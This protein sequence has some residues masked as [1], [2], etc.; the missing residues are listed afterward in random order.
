MYLKTQRA[1]YILEHPSEEY[2]ALFA[3]LRACHRLAHLVLSSVLKK[4][5]QSYETFFNELSPPFHEWQFKTAEAVDHLSLVIPT[6]FEEREQQHFS[7]SPLIHQIMT[8][9]KTDADLPLDIAEDR[10]PAL[11]T[12]QV[13]RAVLC[14]LPERRVVNLDA[15]GDDLNLVKCE[16]FEDQL[17]ESSPSIIRFLD[18]LGTELYASAKLDGTIYRRGEIVSVQ[19]NDDAVSEGF[20]SNTYAQMV[21]FCQI[22]YFYHERDKSKMLHCIWLEHSSNTLLQETAHSQELVFLPSCSDIPVSS[23][24]RRC[25]VTRLDSDET[26]PRDSGDLN[27][28]SYFHRF[29]F[30]PEHSSYLAPPSAVD[31]EEILKINPRSPCVNCVRSEDESS[32]RV[33]KPLG[34]SIDEG[35]VYFDVPYHLG[36]F[37]Y[38]R[39][40]ATPE[41][42]KSSAR[43]LQIGQILDILEPTNPNEQSVRCKIRYYQRYERPESLGGLFNDERRLFRTRYTNYVSEKD[44]DGVCFVQV[45]DVTDSV[46]I[47][48]WITVGGGPD[49]FY[50][51][52]WETAEH[53]IEPMLNEHLDDLKESICD[54]CLSHHK[55]SMEGFHLRHSQLASLDLFAG[56]GGLSAGMEQSGFFETRWAV[57][58]APAAAQTFAANHPNALVVLDDL[59][60]VLQAL[61]DKEE[62][63]TCRPLQRPDG[64]FIPAE[65]LPRRG[66]V[67][68]IIMGPPCQPFSGAN[69]RKARIP[70]DP[71]ALLIY[72]GLGF[73]EILRPIYV[74]IENVPRLLQHKIGDV[75]SATL[76]LTLRALTG[77]GY[78]VAFKVLQAGEFGCAQDRERLIIIAVRLDHKMVSFPT[79]THAC[80]N[81]AQ[82][83]KLPTGAQIRPP[84]RS[85]GEVER[86]VC[87]VHPAVKV[88]DVIGDLPK[89]DWISPSAK[90]K[91]IERRMQKG[92][93]QFRVVNGPVGF[94]DRVPFDLLPQTRVQQM[95]RSSDNTVE[96]HVTEY[97]KSQTVQI[98]CA[99]PLKPWANHRANE[100][101]HAILPNRM[102]KM[103]RETFFSRLDKYG[104]FK[105][106]LT[107]PK[108]YTPQATFLHPT[109]FRCMTLREFVRTQGIPDGRIFKSNKANAS[110]RLEDYFKMVGNAVPLPMAAALGRCIGAQ[111]VE[112]YNKHKDERQGS[113]EFE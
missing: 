5:T 46:A 38:V 98:T 110:Q 104:T 90:Q 108:P 102:H 51:S 25:D 72:V 87:A 55:S 79:P 101:P 49:R 18:P 77:L 84:T 35:F 96:H 94:V 26:Q 29:E 62:G 16:S 82:T 37:V 91:D 75:N 106:A 89:F 27:S 113:V 21:W 31:I 53:R 92:I 1:W 76:K 44:L 9:P 28:T 54:E 6:Y 40:L 74:V 14:H 45:I 68:A 17:A 60:H 86:L 57:E 64:T 65:S 30:D 93:K 83:Y 73:V 7:M 71:R 41:L 19:P 111:L 50:V 103:S 2:A 10:Q 85:T 42:N 95:L 8:Q 11:L 56:A 69:R 34:S 81:P 88:W 112:D 13:A 48:R 97:F 4:K 32:R 80:E 78:Q 22:E 67:D 3:P 39:P 59:N 63:R 107:A 70:N 43:L 58:V 24:R 66:D 100:V 99:V 20:C 15:E 12:P 47:N 105:A 23:I 33:V 36:D 61:V 109:Q 52:E